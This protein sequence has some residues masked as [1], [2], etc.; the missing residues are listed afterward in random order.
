MQTIVIHNQ[1]SG[2]EIGD[3]I[4]CAATPLTRLIGLLGRNHVAAGEGLWIKP[5]SGV[6]TFGMNCAI[7]VVGL[8]RSM[9]VVKLWPRLKPLRMTSISTQIKSVLELAAGEIEARSI[10]IGDVLSAAVKKK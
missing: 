7:D 2:A 8:D 3:R 1:T 6:H 9:R 5:S 10:Q 4:E